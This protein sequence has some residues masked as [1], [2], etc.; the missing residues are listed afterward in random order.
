MVNW[1]SS[2][3]R[4]H[5]RR[6]RRRARERCRR[7][8]AGRRC[9][10]N[11]D[12]RGWDRRGRRS[13]PGSR[14]DRSRCSRPGPGVQP[15]PSM[16]AFGSVTWQPPFPELVAACVAAARLARAGADRAAAACLARAGADRAAACLPRAGAARVAGARLARAGADRGARAGADR[17][18][19]ACL[20]RAAP[21]AEEVAGA[22]RAGARGGRAEEDEPDLAQG[23]HGSLFVGW[24]TGTLELPA[25]Y[26][27]SS[28]DGRVSPTPWRSAST[29][30]EL[31]EIL[32]ITPPSQNVLL[33][34]R[35]G[36]GKS[37]ILTEHYTKKG[38]RVV[39]L[40]LGQ[41]SDPG[42]PPRPARA[43]RR[44]RAHPVHAAVLVAY[45]G[46]AGRALPRRAEPGAPRESSSRCT[47]SP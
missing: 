19:A 6:R 26:S 28:A 12:R 36:I 31:L 14:S 42:D 25:L 30:R 20:P 11:R 22:G 10:C 38:L 35:H 17:A 45:R 34:G 8:R 41:M 1:Q 13:R 37:E 9:R 16:S 21:G 29:A 33:V 3:A 44:E 5:R 27:C 39:A 2:M 32:E 23:T 4:P 15:S 47:T 43:G 18:A 46:Q 40:F 24:S 7:G